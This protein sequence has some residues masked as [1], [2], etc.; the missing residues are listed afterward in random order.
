[1]RVFI[2]ISCFFIT[3]L[4]AQS[5]SVRRL[6]WEGGIAVDYELIK[7]YQFN[8]SLMQRTSF[9]EDNEGSFM[10]LSFLEINHFVTR[11]LNPFLKISV[12]YKYRTDEPVDQLDVFEH[13]FT[14]QLAYTH[15]DRR[16]RLVSRVRLE[17]RIGSVNYAD[18]YR[19]RLSFDVPL[20]GEKIDSGEF[21]LVG[22]SELLYEDL[23]GGRN[24]WENRLSG[25]LG[26]VISKK[27]K[28]DFTITLRLEDIN[29]RTE[30]ILFLN[31]G[32]IVSLN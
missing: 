26:Y 30:E 2:C 17:Q 25:S 14:E 3:V 21:F 6:V 20:R 16:L 9:L 18:R 5:Q 10:A 27:I 28:A 23:K 4:S 15:L 29:I 32:I 8:S 13:R 31:T 24:T 22:S 12:G 11:K 1:M 19:Y 7:D